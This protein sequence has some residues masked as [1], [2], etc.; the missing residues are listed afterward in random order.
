VLSFVSAPDF[1]APTDADANNSYIVQV[2]ATDGLLTDLQTITFNVTNVNEGAN[3]ASVVNVTG[4]I[5]LQ[6]MSTSL[7]PRWIK[8]DQMPFT[9]SDADGDAPV[10]YRFTDVGTGANSAV[11]HYGGAFQAQG[12]TLEVAASQMPVVYLGGGQFAGTDTLRIQVF[13]GLVWSAPADITV[14]TAISPQVPVDEVI[15]SSAGDDV[16]TGGIGEDTF[17]FAAGFGHDTITDFMPGTDAI[18]FDQAVFA[19]VAEVIAHAAND[20]QGN[21]VITA[22]AVDTL[23]I[24]HVTVEALQQHLNDFLIV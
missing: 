13:D 7:S 11:L 16:L 24:E 17:V 8:G 19:S 6:P 4:P 22:T 21:T 1:E 3:V 15:T 14:T 10:L 18:H 23:T 20:G 12:T 2:S 5:Q 9:V